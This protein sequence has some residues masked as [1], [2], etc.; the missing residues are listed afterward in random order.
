MTDSVMVLA[1]TAE[2][3]LE[4]IVCKHLDSVYTPR[5]RSRDWIKTPHRKRGDFIVGGWVPGV[6][7]NWQTVSALLVGAYT[8]QGRLQFCGVVGTGLSA[9]ERR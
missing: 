4:G 2:L 5:V 6:G 1:A 9:A 3:G 7:V 8:S